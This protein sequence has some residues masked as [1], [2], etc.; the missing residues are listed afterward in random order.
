[1]FLF[2][3]ITKGAKEGEALLRTFFAPLKKCVGHRLKVLEVV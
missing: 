2:K 3:P 1:M